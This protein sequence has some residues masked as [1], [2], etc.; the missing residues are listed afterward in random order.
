[1]NPVDELLLRCHPGR[2]TGWGSGS[3]FDADGGGDLNGN[4]FGCGGLFGGGNFRG[5]G[6]GDGCD[7][8]VEGDVIAVEASWTN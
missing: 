5:G 8:R 3:D 1:M 6:R 2:R 4:G 7:S